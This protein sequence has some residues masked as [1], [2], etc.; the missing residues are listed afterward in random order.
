MTCATAEQTRQWEED[1]YLVLRHAVAG[2]ELMRLQQ[3]FDYWAETCKAEWLDR[4]EAGDA[5]PS[6]YDIPDA[7]GR[8]EAFLDLVDHYSYYGILEDFMGGP[9]LLLDLQGRTVPAWPISYSSWH[10]DATPGNPLHIKLQIYLTDVAPGC[11]EFGYVPGSH[12]AGA[13][14][15][16]NV[17]RL[18]SMPGHRTFPGCAGSVIIF[19]GCGK[20]TA[21]DNRGDQPRKSVILIYE[22]RTPGR[23]DPRTYARLSPLC[24]SVERRRLLGLEW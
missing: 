19:N 22:R 3:A 9:M 11:G 10:H 13:G 17:C 1:G 18:E 20:H 2:E 23:F 4:I 21:M 16:P 7:I 15:Y 5:A 8:D 24:T 14:P 6:Y 12:K